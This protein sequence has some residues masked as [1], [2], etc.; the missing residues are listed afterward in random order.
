ME[1]LGFILKD[2]VNKSV[3]ELKTL[4]DVEVEYKENPS[5]WSK[6]EI[7]GHLIDS[8]N[9]NLRR[10]VNASSKEDLIFEAMIKKSGL[11]LRII[12]IIIGEI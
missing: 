1:N 10:F 2:V 6:K 8:A 11:P 5:K 4:S 12:K 9:N 7:L 3:R